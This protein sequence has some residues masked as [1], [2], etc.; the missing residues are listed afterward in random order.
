[1][2]AGLDYQFR[3]RAVGGYVLVRVW[4]VTEPGTWDVLYVD[5]APLSGTRCSLGSIADGTNA[6]ARAVTFDNITITDGA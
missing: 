2:I 6:T 5:P 3:I 4:S 1:M